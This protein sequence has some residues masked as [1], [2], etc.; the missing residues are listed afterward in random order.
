[1]KYYEIL[2]QTPYCG[3]ATSYYVGIPKH[4]D[5]EWD[6]KYVAWFFDMAM[7]NAYEWWDTNDDNYE[8]FDDYASDCF[9]S[10]REIDKEEIENYERW[11]EYL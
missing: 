1:M 4:I 11:F 7:E 6:E 9:Y 8:D 3:E 5:P 2:C 10:I